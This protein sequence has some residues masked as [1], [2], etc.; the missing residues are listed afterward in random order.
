MMLHTKRRPFRSAV[1]SHYG[2]RVGR[3]E[4]PS[5]PWQGG[6]IPLNYTRMTNE[7]EYTLTQFVNQRVRPAGLEPTTPWFEAKY[8][9][10]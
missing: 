2:V 7:I 9:I 6:I 5:P 1:S 10:R 8:S 4:L 3:I